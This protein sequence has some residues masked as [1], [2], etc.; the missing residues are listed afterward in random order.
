MK[1]LLTVPLPFVCL[2]F[3]FGYH[4]GVRPTERSGFMPTFWFIL[5][6]CLRFQIYRTPTVKCC[7]NKTGIFFNTEKS[8]ESTSKTMQENQD[9]T[10][11]ASL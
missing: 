10:F 3:V 6:V 11:S 7:C 1:M 5:A 9:M 8:E 4:G 2:P